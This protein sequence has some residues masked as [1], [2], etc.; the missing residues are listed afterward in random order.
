MLVGGV[1][2]MMGMLAGCAGGGSVAERVERG[3]PTEWNGA[4]PDLLQ[5]GP[6]TIVVAYREFD[7]EVALQLP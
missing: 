1:V 2:L 6:V 5:G 7:E 3:I 4:Q